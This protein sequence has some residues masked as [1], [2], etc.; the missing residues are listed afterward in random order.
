MAPPSSAAGSGGGSGSCSLPCRLHG[1]K[2]R[3]PSPPDE[4]PCAVPRPAWAEEGSSTWL[5]LGSGSGL[6]LGLGSEPGLELEKARAPVAA[7]RRGGSTGAPRKPAPLR[8]RPAPRTAP[9]AA[10]RAVA[11]RAVAG[12]AVAG[13]AVGARCP[14]L[15]RP[16]P[17]PPRPRYRCLR[18]PPT[19][20]AGC[21]R[22]SGR[23]RRRP[24]S[25]ERS[26]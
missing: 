2:L 10:V 7:L 26:R 25:L 1:K 23:P 5:G 8:A 4:V 6:G 11:G 18:P 12:R 9:E 15:A 20:A 24:R 22:A 14:R 13:R 17:P 19:V 16:L 3:A 21:C